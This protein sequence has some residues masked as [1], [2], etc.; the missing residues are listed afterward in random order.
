LTIFGYRTLFGFKVRLG[1]YYLNND[2]SWGLA[3]KTIIYSMGSSAQD[4]SNFPEV[5]SIF[6]VLAQPTPI[7]GS[8]YI[9]IYVPL[10]FDVWN[11]LLAVINSANIIVNTQDT[12]NKEG[13]FHTVERANVSSIIKENKEVFNGDSIDEFFNGAIFKL[14]G[15]QLTEIWY[16]KNFVER[17]PLLRIVSE[18]SLKISQRPGQIFSGDICGYFPFLS[19]F[20]IDGLRGKFMFLEYRYD[21]FTNIGTYKSLELFSGE[22]SDIN[23]KFT[24]DYGQTVKPTITS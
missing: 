9:E 19:V 13:E 24:F 17:K 11:K 4:T 12:T 16:R 2:G 7:D 15:A 10:T 1:S 23:Y 3:N 21:T 20:E 8:V 5:K 6:S 22:L 14:G 18:E